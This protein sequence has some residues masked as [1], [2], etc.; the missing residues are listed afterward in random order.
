MREDKTIDFTI[1][2]THNSIIVKINLNFMTAGRGGGCTPTH[3]NNCSYTNIHKIILYYCIFITNIIVSYI[4]NTYLCQ[5]VRDN[6]KLN[7][8][9]IMNNLIPFQPLGNRVVV[10]ADFEVSTLNILNTDEINKLAAKQYIVVAV[11]DDV[12]CV[13]VGENVLIDVLRGCPRLM[14][15]DWND[16][17]LEKKQNYHRSGKAIVG[18]GTVKFSEYLIVDTIDILGIKIEADGKC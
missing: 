5:R 7:K 12:E 6:S 1:I 2:K 3:A 10:R 17:S 9:K 14:N 13:S 8:N 11:S 16:Q 4:I 18:V 15:F